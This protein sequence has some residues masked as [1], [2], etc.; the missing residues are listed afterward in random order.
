MAR[1][2]HSRYRRPYRNG[3]LNEVTIATLYVVFCFAIFYIQIFSQIIPVLIL[4][5]TA[6]FMFLYKGR[7]LFFIAN[8]K[9][10]L[11]FPLIVL[12]S[13]IVSD[14]PSISL[15]YG[16][17]LCLTIAIGV[18]LGVC[19]TP[20]QLLR[21]IFLAAAVI[22]VASIISGR[23]GS[24]EVGPVLIGLTGSKDQMGFLGM[25]LAAA[26]M[27]VLFDRHQHPYYR[28]P[29]ILLIPLGAYI[30]A[31]VEAAATKLAV[32]GFVFAFLGFLC[33]RY[34]SKFSRVGLAAFVV[35]IIIPAS[36]TVLAL[37]LDFGESGGAVLK[38]LNKDTT[39]TG[40]TLLWAVADNWI[41]QSPVFGH[42]YRSFWLGNSAD[43]IALLS[44]FGLTDG[45]V[46]QFHQTFRE[47]LVDT[48][49]VGLLAFL[50]AA[51]VFFYYV[52][53]NVILYPSASSAFMASMYLL[54]VIRM[55]IESIIIIF[56]PHT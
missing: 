27:A 11:L 23:T 31:N 30:A 13:A 38:A 51:G 26:G 19:A 18:L 33:L 6:L 32:V 43:S 21:G 54:F 55:P 17:Q 14:V 1:R 7:L 16:F 49:W 9:V 53:K 45:R 39:L 15:Y 25:T 3:Q 42:G 2:A 8:N 10:V 46:F 28:I 52:L 56:S 29:A 48:G 5:V 12:L 24:S 47:I 50:A 35:A 20:R 41:E 40:R 22:T 34:V 44:Q 37:M 36:L 4:L